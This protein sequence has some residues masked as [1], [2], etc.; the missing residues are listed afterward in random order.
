M[1]TIAARLLALFVFL[2]VAFPALAEEF[3]RSYHSVVEVAADGKLA[4]TETITAR[5]EGQNIKRGIFRDF[6]LYALDANNRRTKVDFNVVSV[7][8]DG[9]PES[10]RTENID[11]GIRIYTGSADRFLPTGEH[12]FQI[13]YTTARQ[14]RYFSDYDELT[15][16]VTGNGWQFPMGEISATI[17]LPQGVKATDTAVFTGPLGAKGKDARILNE[18]NEV[19][20]A[21]T[22]PFTVGEGMTV[23]VKLPK[24]AIAAPDTSQEAGWWLRDNLAIL[25]SGGGLLAVLFYYLRAWFAVGRDPA[26]GVVVPR[27]DAPEGLSPALVNYVDNRGFSGAG[28]T[29]LSASALDLAV[30]GYV[31]LE[32]LKNSIVIRRTEKAAAADLP[33]GQK[34]LLSSIGGPGET[35]TIDKAHG[36]EV[37]K[38]G[39]QFRA[40]IEKEHRGKYYHSNS[41]YIFFGIFFSIALIVATLVFGDLDEFAIAAVLVFGF[42]AFFFSILS[43]GI[44]RQFSRGASL[45]K[46]IGGIVMLAFAGFVAFSAIGGI[47]TQVLLDVTHDTKS[48]ALAAIGGIVLTNALFLFLMGAPTPLGRKL[49]DGIEG[50][51]TYLTL[52]EKDRMNMAAAPA[53]SPQH[54]ETLL[55]YAVALGVEKPWSRTFET[56][57]ATAAAGAAV[58]SYAPG[59]YLG[60]NYG[61]FGDRIGGFS[62]S[63]ASTIA[64]TIPQPVSSSNSSFSGGGGGGGFSGSGGGGGGGGGW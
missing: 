18:G 64:S 54:F 48:L 57:L 19:F 63:M 45:R 38:V 30:K 3:I 37:E 21:S 31:V 26:K 58:A 20:F 47:A 11:G 23:A 36:A 9:T 14:I 46:R 17:T 61:S 53:M 27:W 32:D 42:F 15:W 50:L 43:I 51:R 16:N 6:P 29:A 35:L 4:V 2:G 39:K 60:S 44:G 49:M 28:W 41:G 56:W 8:R 52:A 10:W 1:K 55:P 24:G 34:T 40:A 62:T 33:T 13:T 5:A 22:R 12:V 59:W 7:E 25:L